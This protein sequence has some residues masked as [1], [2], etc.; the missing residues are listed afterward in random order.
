MKYDVVIIGGGQAG[1]SMGFY[2]KKSDLS[3]II[4]DQA[5]EVGA[6]WKER[7]DSLTLFTPRVYSSVPGFMF[8]GDQEGYPTKDEVVEYLSAYAKEFTLPIQHNTEVQKLVQVENGFQVLTNQGEWFARKVVV[9]TGPFQKPFV[10]AFSKEL[11]ESVFQLHS[12]QYKNATQL[13]KGSVLVVGGGNS[14]AQ[15]AVELAKKREVYLSA[16]H[17][18]KFLPLYIGKRNLFWWFD[19]LGVYRAPVHSK[20]GKFIQKQPDPIIGLELKALL[21]KGKITLKSRTTAIKQDHFMFADGSEVSVKNV[22]WSTGFRS[23]YQWIDVAGVLDENGTPL[24]ERGVTSIH[25]LY[26]LGLPWQFNRSSALLQG[27]GEDA[28]Y[29][30]QHIMKK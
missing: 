4:L 17:K 13:N 19:V 30:I 28:Q 22:I 10:P 5:K 27:V 3:F 29:L 16:G 12:S 23:D 11:S 9:A 8:S 7:Y 25:G 1:L 15:I 20:V 2:L 21:K 26:F 14:G 6:S 24:H 18:L